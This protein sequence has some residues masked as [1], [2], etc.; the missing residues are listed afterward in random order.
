MISLQKWTGIILSAFSA[1][2]IVANIVFFRGQPSIDSVI[3]ASVSFAAV[4]VSIFVDKTWMRTLQVVCVAVVSVFSITSE[5]DRIWDVIAGGFFMLVS[6][7]LAL[8][9]DF[10]DKKPVPIIIMAIL[11]LTFAFSIT[12]KNVA[13]GAGIAFAISGG[14]AILWSIVHVKVR[15]L[16]EI[17]R[18]AVERG[19]EFKEALQERMKDG[20]IHR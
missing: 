19:S 16:Q 6:V 20:K 10:F 18:E 14:C 2:T 9:Y 13:T 8:S 7:S 11:S 1:W 15:R 4:F 3:M 5:P 17:A 12:S